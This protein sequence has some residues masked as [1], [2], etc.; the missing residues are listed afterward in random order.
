MSPHAIRLLALTLIVVALAPAAQAAPGQ[1]PID[2]DVGMSVIAPPPA[3][4]PDRP[5]R[6][7]SGK[8]VRGADPQLP[9][10]LGPYPAKVVVIVY[11]DFQCP[12][13][14][15]VTDATHQIPE[16]W[17]GEVRVEFRQH[18]LAMH[19]NAANAAVASLAAHRQGK[20]WEMHDVLFAH[21][22][23]LDPESLATYAGEIGLDLPRFRH[24]FG[25]PDLRSRVTQ[26][27]ALA[28][29]LGATGTPA[30]LIN[31]RLQVGWG[32]WNGFR[33]QVQQELA[34]VNELLAKGTK[35]TAV[36]ELRARALAKDAAAFQAYKKAVID[37][38]AQGVRRSATKEA[39]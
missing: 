8:V 12:V 29:Q 18:P 19:A 7:S 24:D 15:R 27:G 9:P 39:S 20:F 35:L 11:S 23:A 13:C 25:D 1:E 16:E 26:E 38:R 37:S 33:S 14:A 34:V 5:T 4:D 28:D 6:T 31:G 32:S 22:A 21:Q 17:P 2:S 10:A 30:F 36:H 3:P